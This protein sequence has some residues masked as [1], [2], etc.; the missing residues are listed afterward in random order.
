[1]IKSQIN[2]TSEEDTSSANEDAEIRKI[3]IPCPVAIPK[4]RKP[5]KN[6]S[7]SRKEHGDQYRKK[8][9]SAGKGKKVNRS[10]VEKQESVNWPPGFAKLDPMI[11]QSLDLV[12]DAFIS[13][14]QQTKNQKRQKNELCTKVESLLK[15][16]LLPAPL[17][18]YKDLEDV[19]DYSPIEMRE[20]SDKLS[21]KPVKIITPVEG[22]NTEKDKVLNRDNNTTEILSSSPRDESVS[23]ELQEQ[24]IWYTQP[25]DVIFHSQDD[26]EVSS[27]KLRLY[28]RLSDP[29]FSPD[30]DTGSVSEA[31]VGCLQSSA[32][33]PIGFDRRRNHSF[34][35]DDSDD[36]WEGSLLIPAWLTE[37]ISKD[38]NVDKALEEIKS[39]SPFP[40]SD[41]GLGLSKLADL[42][43]SDDSFLNLNN[44][45][46]QIP[47]LEARDFRNE[48]IWSDQ[49]QGLDDNCTPTPEDI[50]KF[51]PEDSTSPYDELVPVS[52]V[53]LDYMSKF[54]VRE[55]S[56]QSYSPEDSFSFHN[57]RRTCITALW[58]S[59]VLFDD[60]LT[61]P[62]S[63]SDLVQPVY[64]LYDIHCWQPIGCSPFS[65][66]WDVNMQKRSR[67]S[68]WGGQ[69]FNSDSQVWFAE[70]TLVFLHD[71]SGI[72]VD[73]GEFDQGENTLIPRISID[74]VSEA[75]TDSSPFPTEDELE[76]G[77]NA[78][79]FDRSVSMGDVPSLW[80][81]EY[82]R[83]AD[84][85]LSKSF[86]LVPSEHSAF[87][88]VPRKLLHVHSEPNLVQFRQDFADGHQSAAHSPQEHLYFSP[89]THFRPITPAYVPELYNSKSKQQVCHDLFGGLPS[90]K[91]PYQQ[92]QVLEKES[93]EEG[94]I[95]RFK[96]KNYS[97]SIQTGESFE[98]VESP[99]ESNETL[100]RDTPETL[101]LSMIEDVME[102]KID[103]LVSIE[104]DQ[105]AANT[106]SAYETDYGGNP[107]ADID[108][109][110]QPGRCFYKC[111]EHNKEGNALV[112]GSSNV[113]HGN[114]GEVVNY[115]VQSFVATFPH[116][117]DW[118][119]VSA[120]HTDSHWAETEQEY[121]LESWPPAECSHSVK[122]D[123]NLDGNYQTHG[124]WG[125]DLG[126]DHLYR[127]SDMEKYKNIWSSAG[128]DYYSVDIGINGN[129]SD[130]IALD[131]TE[132]VFENVPTDK[133]YGNMFIEACNGKEFFE[134]Q[135]VLEPL[136]Q[137][138]EALPNSEGIFP[139]YAGFP[140]Q[141]DMFEPSE[142]E[143]TPENDTGD[144]FSVKLV[145]KDK[146]NNEE[147][148]N[149][150]QVSM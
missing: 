81:D 71:V 70:N 58:Q 47:V 68:V 46:C 50:Q 114:L 101:T 18:T 48:D 44:A 89:K 117:N 97:K 13:P 43:M 91:T 120:K 37:E 95:P 69:I 147:N 138:I 103:Q 124:M 28:K 105:D 78:G 33:S 90:T 77:R 140:D 74:I 20:K 17:K 92:Y 125:D 133:Y 64:E 99:A 1:M 141:E 121:H 31:A 137:G 42:S 72:S 53:D 84:P 118:P 61:V 109:D 143:L 136:D 106:D 8:D 116:T 65:Q 60:S 30:Q 51:L 25:I 40:E 36:I 34:A 134:Y 73:V 4:H 54:I 85:K 126:L 93:D 35:S 150:I 132:E 122:E 24:E 104:E 75:D 144:Y 112:L 102:E 145:Y 135:P 127:E 39:S 49:H 79:Y 128:Q 67:M 7:R 45:D 123:E 9:K 5:R 22:M 96:L 41:S 62:Y 88:D 87:N 146:Q 76:D 110:Q 113:D 139:T 10:H 83:G 129:S 15:G 6:N 80:D 111:K 21:T 82:P 2:L 57:P 59:Q 108:Q 29:A 142:M 131:G 130:I 11:L 32:S 66:L 19:D 86:E 98:K 56:W 148:Q 14:Q 63:L 94:F 115:T 26:Y 55:P 100:E 119:D 23:P 12:D 38:E 3:N 149:Q 52:L 27:S 16:M 107:G